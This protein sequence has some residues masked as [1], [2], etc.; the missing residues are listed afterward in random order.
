MIAHLTKYSAK[1]VGYTALRKGK[2]VDILDLKNRLLAL[3][4]RILPRSVTT[5]V[6]K[7]W[8]ENGLKE[9]KY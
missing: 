9:T 6:M 2:T 4:A 8:M 5:K 1:Q 7:L 3:L